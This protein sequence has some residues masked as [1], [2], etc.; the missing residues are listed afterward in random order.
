MDCRV[1]GETITE[2]RD[3]VCVGLL[4]SMNYNFMMLII[5]SYGILLLGCF[6][7]CAGVRHYQHLQKMQVNVG[8][9]GVPVSISSNRIIDKFDS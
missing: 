3:S 8:Y 7:V 5:I 4:Y 1:V 2:L 9:K 6:S